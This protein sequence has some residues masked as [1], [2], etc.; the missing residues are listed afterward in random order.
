MGIETLLTHSLIKIKTSKLFITTLMLLAC[1]DLFSLSSILNRWVLN[2]HC[3]SL[4]VCLQYI[5]QKDDRNESCEMLS[6][7]QTLKS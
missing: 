4:V 5:R 6:L 3:S 1:F 2:W 7:R